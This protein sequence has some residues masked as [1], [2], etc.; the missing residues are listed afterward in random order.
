[1]IFYAISSR[2]R[3]RTGSVC[4]MADDFF[5]YWKADDVWAII[6]PTI[7]EKDKTRVELEFG[8]LKKK[9]N[10]GYYLLMIIATSLR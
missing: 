7:P 5:Y 2:N 10:N 6:E 9:G 8:K 3:V 4:D 1:M